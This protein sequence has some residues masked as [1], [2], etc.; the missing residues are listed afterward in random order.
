MVV[1]LLDLARIRDESNRRART[2]NAGLPGTLHKDL[3]RRLRETACE[4]YEAVKARHHRLL[5][6]SN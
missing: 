1:E 3:P 6:S 2:S 5:K 4:S